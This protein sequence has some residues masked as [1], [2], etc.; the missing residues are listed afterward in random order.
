M[1][2]NVKELFRYKEVNKLKLIERLNSVGT[3][4]ES[5]AE[6]TWSTLI[7][8]DYYLEKVQ[9]KLDRTKVYEL[10]IYHDLVEIHAGDNPLHPHMKR[11]DMISEEK[12]VAEQ[13]RKELPKELGEK[14]YKLFLEF[15][16]EKTPEARFCKAV[17]VFDPM[18]HEIDYK[19][20]WKGWT[21]KFLLDKK[22]K[23]FEDFPEIK[24][25]F[26]DLVEEM[27]NQGYL[28]K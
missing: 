6:H 18:I 24:Q 22:L 12:K 3:R 25:D 15:E 4:K 14:F 2:P 9:Q 19:K 21:G 13:L 16:E 8:A 20:D 1:K 28:E 17:E 5:P 10:L 26:L 27:E 23:Y 7:L 11:K